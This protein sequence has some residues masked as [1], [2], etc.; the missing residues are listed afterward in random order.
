M[1]ISE[2]LN[3]ATV[4]LLIEEVLVE[5]L[6]TGVELAI[7]A[8]NPRPELRGEI[9]HLSQQRRVGILRVYVAIGPIQP[10]FRKP[11]G[12]APLGEARSVFWHESQLGIISYDRQPLLGADLRSVVVRPI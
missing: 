9:R 10:W 7:V 11:R 3:I 4:P 5:R 6:V 8:L 12:P 2:S 1:R